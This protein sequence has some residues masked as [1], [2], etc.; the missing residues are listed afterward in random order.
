MSSMDFGN[1]NDKKVLVV[2]DNRVNLKVISMSLNQFGVMADCTGSGEEAVTMVREKEYDMVIMDILMP[3]MNGMETTKAIRSLD[4]DYC[5][6][7][8]IVAWTVDNQDG[9]EKDYFEAGMNDL[10]Q[11]PVQMDSLKEMLTKYLNW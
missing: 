4:Y 10:L 11:K 9:S 7:M 3:G 2:D 5:K 1:F 6:E 8:P